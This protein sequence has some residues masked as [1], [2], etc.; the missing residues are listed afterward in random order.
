MALAAALP[1]QAVATYNVTGTTN[2]SGTL[3]TY[4]SN[5]R[6]H[7]VTGNITIKVTNGV[8]NGAK[9]GMIS[10]SG[11]RLAMSDPMT[12][13]SKTWTSVLAGKYAIQAQ[14]GACSL[15]QKLLGCDNSWSGSVTL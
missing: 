8:T 3:V 11:K 1:A 14:Q 2:T 15:T 13:G 9:Y 7:S 10:Q 12:T 4:S 5:Y 6:T